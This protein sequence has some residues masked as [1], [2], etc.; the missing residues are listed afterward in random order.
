MI[1]TLKHYGGSNGKPANIIELLV[2]GYN[3][4]ILEE[5]TKLDGTVD[6]C[7]IYSLKGIVNDLEKQNE[8]IK[9]NG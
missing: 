4:M 6:K 2:T 8:L 9:E 5:I 1:L 3:S 7:L